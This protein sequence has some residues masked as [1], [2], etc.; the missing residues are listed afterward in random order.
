MTEYNQLPI[1]AQV[2]DYLFETSARTEVADFRLTLTLGPFVKE[3]KNHS[4]NIATVKKR[5]QE[6]GKN[7]EAGGEEG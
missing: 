6:E 3:R 1:I 4:G 5:E 7:E 2:I